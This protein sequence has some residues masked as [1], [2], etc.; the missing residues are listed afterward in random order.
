MQTADKV[1]EQMLATFKERGKVYKANYLMIGEILSIM[2]PEGIT[3]RTPEDHN[4]WHLFMMTMIK[5]TRLANT[6]LNHE[7]SGLDMAVYASMFAGMLLP[8]EPNP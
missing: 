1:M 5:A 6:G 4:R 3:L 2:F 7:D 8:D